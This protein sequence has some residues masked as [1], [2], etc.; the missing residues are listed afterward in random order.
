MF[1]E[2]RLRGNA[3]GWEGKGGGCV[4]ALRKPRL[5]TKKMDGHHR[6]GEREGEGERRE[7][8][9]EKRERE[10]EKRKSNG[11]EKEKETERD[12]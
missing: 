1:L 2:E 7:G 4:I 12:Q 6:K 8:E 11:E 10:I 3:S 5:R 9:I